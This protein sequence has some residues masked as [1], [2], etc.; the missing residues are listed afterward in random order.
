MVL[1]ISSPGEGARCRWHVQ[2]V[3]YRLM[4]SAVWIYDVSWEVVHRKIRSS[5]V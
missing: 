1:I 3:V 2:R 5:L 4:V